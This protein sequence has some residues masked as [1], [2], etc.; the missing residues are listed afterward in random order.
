[1]DSLVRKLTMNL[2]VTKKLTWKEQVMS[3]TGHFLKDPN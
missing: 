1:M 3:N 2:L